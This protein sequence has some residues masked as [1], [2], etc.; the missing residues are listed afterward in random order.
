MTTIFTFKKYSRTFITA[1][2][3]FFL[4]MNFLFFAFSTNNFTISV[5]KD[6]DRGGEFFDGRIVIVGEDNSRIFRNR[7]GR[8]IIWRKIVFK[9]EGRTKKEVIG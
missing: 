1:A 2:S 8:D 5:F 7:H 3:L 9:N 6:I 4:N